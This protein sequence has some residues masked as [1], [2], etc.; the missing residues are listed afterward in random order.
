M[1]RIPCGVLVFAIGFNFKYIQQRIW[2][3]KASGFA[4]D[5]GTLYQT[6]VEGLRIGASLTNFGTDM[7]MTGNLK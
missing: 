2:K 4:V 7:K 3:E 1:T 5:I 6:P